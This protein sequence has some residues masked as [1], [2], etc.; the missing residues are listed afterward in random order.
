MNGVTA[1]NELVEH[2]EAYDRH[3]LKQK[4]HEHGVFEDSP[5]TGR[6]DAIEHAEIGRRRYVIR[7]SLQKPFKLVGS[8]LKKAAKC[9]FGCTSRREDMTPVVEIVED[10]NAGP[11]PHDQYNAHIPSIEPKKEANESQ[12]RSE[13]HEQH[14]EPSGCRT[15]AGTGFGEQFRNQGSSDDKNKSNRDS[16]ENKYEDGM[17]SEVLTAPLEVKPVSLGTSSAVDDKNKGVSRSGSASIV[18]L[19][20]GFQGG[21][22]NTTLE[23]RNAAVEG[24]N[25]DLSEHKNSDEF[26]ETFVEENILM[27]SDNPYEDTEDDSIERFRANDDLTFQDDSCLQFFASHSNASSDEAESGRQG[28]YRTS[29]TGALSDRSFQSGSSNAFAKTS[30]GSSSTERSTSHSNDSD[31]TREFSKD[32]ETDGNTDSENEGGGKEDDENPWRAKVVA[33][34]STRSSHDSSPRAGTPSAQ[35]VNSESDE[36]HNVVDEKSARSE[37]DVASHSSRDSVTVSGTASE[38]VANADRNGYH[39]EAGDDS[40]GTVGGAGSHT[41]SDSASQEGTS[42]EPAVISASDKDDDEVDDKS[43]RNA[44]ALSLHSPRGSMLLVGIPSQQ[45]VNEKSEEDHGDVEDEGVELAETASS[46]TSSDSNSTSYFG[47]PSEQSS[48]EENPEIHRTSE[49]EQNDSV[50]GMMLS[51]LRSVLGSLRHGNSD[52]QG[53]SRDTSQSELNSTNDAGTSRDGSEDEGEVATLS[54]SSSRHSFSAVGRSTGSTGVSGSGHGSQSKD[55]D[56]ENGIDEPSQEELALRHPSTHD[57]DDAESVTLPSYSSGASFQSSGHTSQS[58]SSGVAE[59]LED[60]DHSS[61]AMGSSSN[62]GSFESLDQRSRS[63]LHAS[64]CNVSTDSDHSS[65]VMTSSSAD[66]LTDSDEVEYTEES[67]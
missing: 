47:S 6:G 9:C 8:A 35:A 64:T 67:E 10:Q 52:V 43:A 61:Q 36:N 15:G 16:F 50:L 31:D 1:D 20:S 38:Q 65:Q 44:N 32:R 56:E 5:E 51:K 29:F 55:S 18:D 57:H 62:A 33:S 27:T 24:G 46:H 34:Q 37:K 58:A 54:V 3:C 4:D 60:S 26:G 48:N 30:E 17:K 45:A 39:E 28:S 63:S 19:S 13:H 59:S 41:L 25:R 7:H 49:N 22:G 40:A 12:E 11:S 2:Q 42:S 23:F 14:A 21:V 53:E 66:M